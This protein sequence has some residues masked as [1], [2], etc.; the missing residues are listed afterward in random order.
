MRVL[1]E[2]LRGLRPLA[3][4]YPL[5]HLRASPFHGFALRWFRYYPSRNAPRS[6][7]T[8]GATIGKKTFQCRDRA[9]LV[10]TQGAIVGKKTSK[11]IICTCL[12]EG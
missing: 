6:G 4:G 12:R 10:S 5:H 1:G 3:S 9:C 2:P 8:Q 11:P 7:A